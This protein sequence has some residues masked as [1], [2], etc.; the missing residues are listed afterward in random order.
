ML[1][2]CNKTLD[3]IRVLCVGMCLRYYYMLKKVYVALC[4]SKL[5]FIFYLMNAW[6]FECIEKGR[7]FV[8]DKYEEDLCY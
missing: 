1:L 4:E 2:A 8:I 3:I 6:R 5:M 7:V